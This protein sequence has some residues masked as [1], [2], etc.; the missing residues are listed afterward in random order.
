MS[1][2]RDDA[3]RQLNDHHTEMAMKY[4]RFSM[5][6]RN[7]Q[8]KELVAAVG[9]YKETR[10]I[11]DETYSTDDVTGMLD[12]LTETLRADLSRNL[13]RVSHSNVVLLRQLFAQAEDTENTL[14][15]DTS[16][17]E[18]EMLLS[19]V[20]KME[21]ESQK[22]KQDSLVASHQASSLKGGQ[23]PSLDSRK[24]ADALMSG[25]AQ[26]KARLIE[27]QQELVNVQREKTVLNDKCMALE[28][29]KASATV[30]AVPPASDPAPSSEDSDAL[31]KELAA[32][33]AEK[34]A[35]DK[36]VEELTA[37]M[38]MKLQETPQFRAM[39]DMMAKKNSQI[40]T[41]R[42]ALEGFG[43]TDAEAEG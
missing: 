31:K 18:D 16:Y 37:A 19:L 34:E 24:E 9:D 17:L 21:E 1:S 4:I 15:V 14:T 38:D 39:K 6:Q 43:W 33:K 26:L 29:E 11:A 10:L 40:K 8:L 36:A 35:A 42:E 41:M 20:A 5:L 28:E 7:E 22:K 12:S 32:L 2:A 30:M 27:L 25:N 13:Q 3:R 23:L